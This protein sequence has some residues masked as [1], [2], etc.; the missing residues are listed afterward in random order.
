MYIDPKKHR[1]DRKRRRL[2]RSRRE[3]ER[4]A[5]RRPV[6]RCPGC[7]YDLSGL[8]VQP[9]P[10]CGMTQP[11]RSEIYAAFEREHAA[12]LLGLRACYELWRP[13][14]VLAVAAAVIARTPLSAGLALASVVLMILCRRLSDRARN[15][16][17]TPEEMNRFSALR[18][19]RRAWAA[20]NMV[21][22]ALAA[23]ASVVLIFIPLTR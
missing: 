8:T 1:L 16:M 6:D 9:C 13:V 17:D 10:E 3:A 4:L 2:E 20:F 21:A 5:A 15:P 12:N 23:L 22:M 11:E 19:R 14:A 18:V 7:W